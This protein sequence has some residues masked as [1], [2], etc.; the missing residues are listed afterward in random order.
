MP[1]GLSQLRHRQGQEQT[2]VPANIQ[3]DVKVLGYEVD[4]GA[5][6]DIDGQKNIV[7]ELQFDTSLNEVRITADGLNAAYI[8]PDRPKVL[9]A[10]ED[11]AED[12]SIGK[13]AWPDVSLIT[14]KA[15]EKPR[16]VM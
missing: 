4:V 15:Q 6:G 13:T 8:D 16:D 14:Y 5:E 12:G 1:S 2:G 3:K 9:L 11:D 10:S 7:D